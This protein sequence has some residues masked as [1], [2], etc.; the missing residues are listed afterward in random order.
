MGLGDLGNIQ[1]SGFIAGFC[2]RVA[3]S[4]GLSEGTLNKIGRNGHWDTKNQP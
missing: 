2:L 3:H 1:N 4:A